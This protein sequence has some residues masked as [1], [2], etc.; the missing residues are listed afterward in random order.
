MY[1]SNMTNNSMGVDT[2]GSRGRAGGG[3]LCCLLGVFG[4]NR[5]CSYLLCTLSSTL[6][7]I[8][9]PVYKYLIDFVVDILSIESLV[10]IH[11]RLFAGRW[12]GC[13]NVHVVVPAYICCC[14]RT[15]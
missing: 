9:V 12:C 11:A 5:V 15:G 4:V 10:E 3:C 6:D 2:I 14:R 7:T 13:Y 1:E 8:G